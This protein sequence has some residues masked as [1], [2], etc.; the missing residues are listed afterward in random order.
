MI[1][2]NHHLNNLVNNYKA[3]K[4][5]IFYVSLKMNIMYIYLIQFKVGNTSVELYTVC[6]L[7]LL[8]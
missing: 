8:Y 7:L 1:I 3:R 2:D 5:V 4:Y 6:D